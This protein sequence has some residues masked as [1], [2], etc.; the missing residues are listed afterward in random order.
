MMVDRK[1]YS[2]EEKR[3]ARLLRQAALRHV[4]REF[5]LAAATL[6]EAKNLVLWAN[7]PQWAQGYEFL[8]QW[9]E[10]VK[11]EH[12]GKAPTTAPAAWIHLSQELAALLETGGNWTEYLEGRWKVEAGKLSRKRRIAFGVLGFGTLIMSFVILWLTVQGLLHEPL[13]RMSM[14]ELGRENLL[15]ALLALGRLLGTVLMVEHGFAWARKAVT[16]E[17]DQPNVIFIGGTGKGLTLLS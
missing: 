9:R 14:A 16:G 1:L 13:G 4:R 3:L 10:A 7:R 2:L 6:A 11:L 15:G 5:G 12:E 17:S 8:S